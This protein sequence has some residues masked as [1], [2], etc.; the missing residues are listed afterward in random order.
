MLKRQKLEH[1][2][3]HFLCLFTN[4]I[5]RQTDNSSSIPFIRFVLTSLSGIGTFPHR[6]FVLMFL[7]YIWDFLILHTMT[8]NHK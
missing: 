8:D 4:Q 1:E 7:N 3:S 2:A 5:I 6:H